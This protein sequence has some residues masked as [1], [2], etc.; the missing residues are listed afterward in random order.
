MVLLFILIVEKEA[1]YRHDNGGFSS[2][3]PQKP[4]LN[5]KI[6]SIRSNVVKYKYK[7]I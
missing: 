6:A 1:D 5:V 2:R 7:Q 3:M 4:A